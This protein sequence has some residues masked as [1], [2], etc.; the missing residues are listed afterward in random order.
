[1]AQSAKL[2][3]GNIFLFVLLIIGLL[4]YFN[5]EQIN[6]DLENLGILPSEKTV[7]PP[8]EDLQEEIS[9]EEE[10]AGETTEEEANQVPSFQILTKGGGDQLFVGENPI[11]IQATGVDLANVTPIA[12]GSWI[13]I[14]TIDKERGLYNIK[15]QK[16]GTA[17]INLF[18]KIDGKYGVVGNRAFKVMPKPTPNVSAPLNQDEDLLWT[19]TQLDGEEGVL[20]VGKNS[21]LEVA[22]AEVDPRTIRLE[23][24]GE[25]N[26]IVP[27]DAS[28]GKFKVILSNNVA[29]RVNIT[30]RA[31][32]GGRP[33]I[34]GAKEFK[35]KG[36][37][38]IGGKD[39][40]NGDNT[41]TV[42]KNT[43]TPKIEKSD[44]ILYVGVDYPFNI[45]D[46]SIDPKKLQFKGENVR[47]T[48]NNGE[49]IMK[50]TRAGQV[51]VEI[52][53]RSN[54]KSE[55]METTIYQ[56]EELPAPIAMIQ[57][58][59]GG[60]ISVADMRK[61]LNLQFGYNHLD[62]QPKFQLIRCKVT[63]YPSD[64][65][66]ESKLNNGIVFT[67]S[68]RRLFLEA[69]AGDLY[70]ITDIKVKT[71]NNKF[72]EVESVSFEVK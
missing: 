30:V 37:S 70:R 7:E 27:T 63:R 18:A 65:A 68:T 8:I 47:I 69:Q 2:K 12:E 21:E 71:P 25:G 52:Y 46:P 45:D 38:K 57:N 26:R 23:I 41:K 56:A 6:S 54:G 15:P 29:D 39:N 24:N 59:N 34:I 1:M 53:D 48:G 20:E 16:R 61:T 35:V 28:K 67:T 11:I 62:I 31:K 5:R 22:I 64:T 42:E 72:L 49:Y 9:T 14:E 58:K 66:P 13:D 50:V 40:N 33:Q 10:I 60:K 36:S 43:P 51:K 19:I 44:A 32:V 17:K 4:Y 3:K 55:L